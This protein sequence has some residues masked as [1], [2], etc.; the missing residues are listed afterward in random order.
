LL[1]VNF[2]PIFCHKTLNPD[3]IRIRNQPKMLDPD[4]YQMNT[5]PKPCLPAHVLQHYLHTGC[6]LQGLKA[7]RTGTYLSI[8]SVCKYVFFHAAILSRVMTNLKPTSESFRING[9]K[10]IYDNMFNRGIFLC[11]YFIQYLLSAAP[12]VPLC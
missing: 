1:A 4:P 6:S 10:I 9:K 2:F 5:D 7:I 3:W 12:Q 8:R 11:M